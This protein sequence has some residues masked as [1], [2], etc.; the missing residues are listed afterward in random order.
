MSDD[1]ELLLNNINK[2]SELISKFSPDFVCPASYVSGRLY[3]GSRS[4]QDIRIIDFMFSA[5]RMPGLVF[6]VKSVR[7]YLRDVIMLCDRGC[8]F[9]RMYPQVVLLMLLMND[10]GKCI[11]FPHEI[12]RLGFNVASGLVSNNGR[13]F[14][15]CESRVYQL[16]D[17][18]KIINSK[19]RLELR[20]AMIESAVGSYIG[21]LFGSLDHLSRLKILI[22]L[23]KLVV[24]SQMMRVFPAQVKEVVKK[25]IR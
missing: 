21:R 15:H 19:I 10:G 9:S 2:L 16:N 12:E 8:E 23:I 3:R 1:D 25:L 17:L 6:R 4:I 11:Y 7:I 14:W 13:S 5:S 24:W 18:C 22:S 20:E